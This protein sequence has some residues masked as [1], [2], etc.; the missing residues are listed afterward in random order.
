MIVRTLRR[1]EPWIA[2][3]GS[4]MVLD[5][6]HA[7]LP[8]DFFACMQNRREREARVRR[9]ILHRGHALTVEGGVVD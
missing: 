4:R 2:R 5:R 1:V 3:R 9:G 6:S 8:V 7:V